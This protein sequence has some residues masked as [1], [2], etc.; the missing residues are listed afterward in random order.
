MLLAKDKEKKMN[1]LK[2]GRAICY[3]GYREGQSPITGVYPSYEQIKEDLQILDRN[4]DYIRMYDPSEHAQTA[5]EV[6]KNEKLHL[7]VILGIDLQ[8]EISN[9]QCAWGGVYSE[10]ELARHVENNENNLRELIRLANLYSDI[11]VAVSAGNEAVPEWNENLVSPKRV[12]Y[13]VKE[14]K[15]HTNQLVTYCENNHYWNNLLQEVAQEVD[16]I[17][18]HTYPLWIG[19]TIDN[20]LET[21][22]EDYEQIANFYP[23]KPC[24]ITEAG[25]TTQSNGRGILPE[26]AGIA[27]QKRYLKEM[28][29]WSE[30]NQVL[31]F[32]FEAF[33]EPWKGTDDPD[34][35]EKHWGIYD[36]SRKLK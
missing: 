3:S 15:K 1:Q 26:N 5:L 13:F 32:F 33:D 17:S 16:F 12:L 6:I 22:I 4:Y 18:L 36:V 28:E 34:E 2:Y 10:S 8:G 27:F 25:W 23:N 14:L 9:P 11:I 35:P 24:I 20:A 29:R 31:V 7:K 30:E 19:K 21:S